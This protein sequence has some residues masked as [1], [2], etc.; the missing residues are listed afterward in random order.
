MSVRGP[1]D[2]D[3]REL[4]ALSLKLRKT[5]EECDALKDLIRNKDVQI[6]HC[7]E[8]LNGVLSNLQDETK[9]AQEFEEKFFGAQ[10]VDGFISCGHRL[11]IDA[12]QTHL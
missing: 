1:W 7:G 6:Q 11:V 8:K 9:R 3:D 12:V 2:R 5:Q 10:E 4:Q